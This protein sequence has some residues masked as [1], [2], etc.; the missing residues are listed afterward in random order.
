MIQDI[1]EKTH[2]LFEFTSAA[3]WKKSFDRVNEFLYLSHANFSK[4]DAKNVYEYDFSKIV[5][6][7][8]EISVE[9]FC[10]H[11]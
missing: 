2:N 6:N 7:V 9:W 5:K 11:L 10:L 8:H 1:C 3:F 4:F